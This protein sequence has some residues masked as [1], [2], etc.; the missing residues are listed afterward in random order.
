MIKSIHF[1]ESLPFAHKILE[2]RETIYVHFNSKSVSWN[3]SM[4]KSIIFHQ[5][6]F[7]LENFIFKQNI[8]FTPKRKRSHLNYQYIT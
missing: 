3:T 8:Y 1:Y 4:F 2:L 6:F 5:I 7:I